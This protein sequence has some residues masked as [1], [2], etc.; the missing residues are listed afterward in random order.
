MSI[1]ADILGRMVAWRQDLHAHPELAFAE[2]RTGDLVARELA[3]CGFEVHRGLGRTGVVGTLRR[4]EGPA[5]GLRADM[6]ALPIQ[7]ATGLPH[8]SRP[9]A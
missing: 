4:G 5:V 7:E 2:V 3:A 6:D 8:A 1:D 9:R